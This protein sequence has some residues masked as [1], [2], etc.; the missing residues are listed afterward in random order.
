MDTIRRVNSSA[1]MTLDELY[2]AR[3]I[4]DKY[5]LSGGGSGVE[6]G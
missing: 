6:T 2:W 1:P 5:T 3:R 4:L